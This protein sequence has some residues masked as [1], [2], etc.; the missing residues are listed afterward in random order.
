MD[1]GSNDS[2]AATLETLKLS[3]PRQP[4]EV[5]LIEAEA[6]PSDQTYPVEVAIAAADDD[7]AVA[8]AAPVE[9][10]ADVVRRQYNTGPQFAGKSNEEVAAIK[11]QTAF[12]V[13]LVCVATSY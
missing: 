9:A 7:D 8:L 2:D 5:K 12:R 13:Y 4:Q 3:P 1:L 6:E 11:I 10:V